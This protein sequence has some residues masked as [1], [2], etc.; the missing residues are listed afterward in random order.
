MDFPSSHC[1]SPS[2]SI[3][4]VLMHWRTVFYVLLL[5]WAAACLKCYSHCTT[6][7]TT[8]DCSRMC[9]CTDEMLSRPLN[10][11]RTEDGAGFLIQ[12]GCDSDCRLTCVSL[13]Q[14][15]SLHQCLS[16]CEC[17]LTRGELD[18]AVTIELVTPKTRL[19]TVNFVHQSEVTRE[20]KTEMES[21][22]RENRG[23]EGL[24]EGKR[25][26]CA[27]EEKG[28]GWMLNAGVGLVVVAV[29]AGVVWTN[30]VKPQ[31]KSRRPHA[32]KIRQSP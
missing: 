18:D 15:W 14:G 25:E 2:Q 19:H 8:T 4:L 31:E 22:Q 16:A 27:D 29:V 24:E 7:M 30:C 26:T 20:E 9:G 11:F 5:N 6:D 13:S 3:C 23:N 10:F 1:L 12:P 17:Q 32:R 28:E 21:V